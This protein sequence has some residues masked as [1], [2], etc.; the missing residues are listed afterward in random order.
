MFKKNKILILIPAR[1]GSKR[2]PNKNIINF[3]G[4]TL[5]THTILFAEKLKFID[6][7][8]VSSDSKKILS[9]ARKFGTEAMPR[10]TKLSGDKVKTL[11]VIKFVLSEIKKRGEKFDYLL[12]LEVTSPLRNKKTI[13]MAI[14]KIIEKKLDFVGTVIADRS[15]FWR[16]RGSKFIELFPGAPRRSQEREPLYKTAGVCYLFRISSLIN[17][18]DIFAGKKDFIIVNPIEAIDINIPDD[19]EIARYFFKKYK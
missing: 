15:L 18:N 11:P 7:I 4:K 14:N 9:V 16:S 2:I 19:L 12:L 8:I 17:K 1:G 6:K 3:C 5:L 10:P 13:E